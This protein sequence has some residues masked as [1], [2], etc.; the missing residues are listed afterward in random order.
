MQLHESVLDPRLQPDLGAVQLR[1]RLVALVAGSTD[2]SEVVE[3][4]ELL[5]DI[6][7]STFD[8]LFASFGGGFKRPL[9][10]HLWQRDAVS[11]VAQQHEGIHLRT[12]RDGAVL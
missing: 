6:F 3:S 4:V 11:D 9:L 5:E 7:P 10:C 1:L 2:Q 12:P 8:L